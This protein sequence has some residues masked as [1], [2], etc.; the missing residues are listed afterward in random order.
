MADDIVDLSLLGNKMPARRFNL[1]N[2]G[3]ALQPVLGNQD[4]AMALLA[5]SGPSPV[6]RS[7]GQIFGQSN[8][9][10]QAMQMKRQEAALGS[11]L[12]QAQISHLLTPPARKPIAVIGA[13]G[14]P[15]YVDENDAPG[16]QPYNM[17]NQ[18]ELPRDIQMFNLENE[19]R[20]AAG[21]KP[22]ATPLEY[23]AEEYQKRPINPTVQTMNNTPTLVQ[24]IDRRGNVTQTPLSTPERELGA[25]NAMAGAKQTGEDIAK[26][27]SAYI[28]AGMAAAERMP[29][30]KRTL[31]LLDRVETG[32][33]DTLKLYATNTFGVTGADEGELSANLGKSILAQL[34][35]IFG[36]QFTE[37]EGKRLEAIESSFGKS[38]AVNRRLLQEA[39]EIAQTAAERGM[40]AAEAAGDTVTQK[41]I[42]RYLEKQLF[43]KKQRSVDEILNDARKR[44]G[45]S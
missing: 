23:L 18:A 13:D 20:I 16:K 40:D 21:Q 11:F 12:T 6:P 24:P 43:E 7:F 5:N 1:R 44:R 45:G 14:K 37:K 15:V 8:I 35:P 22:F 38:T 19:R 26:R 30:L 36:S 42:K 25:A 3:Q 39:V 17:G 10:A 34:R 2:L 4:L 29:V 32:G 28:D 33:L 27:N 9:D 41:Q 31:D